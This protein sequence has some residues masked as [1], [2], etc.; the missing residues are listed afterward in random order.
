MDLSHDRSALPRAGGDPL[1]RTAA[2]VADGE[3]TPTARLQRQGFRGSGPGG[4]GT[5]DR[6]AVVIQQRTA[7][8][9]AA[10]GGFSLSSNSG[11]P[12]SLERS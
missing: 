5:G 1:G 2:G 6:K 12:F 11:S 4:I 9:P 8:I 10:A 3:N 7:L